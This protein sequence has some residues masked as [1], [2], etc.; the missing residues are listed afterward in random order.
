MKYFRPCEKITEVIH[1]FDTYRN[2]KNVVTRG[3]FNPYSFGTF[4]YNKDSG[5]FNFRTLFNRCEY[6]YT[7]SIEKGCDRAWMKT[8]SPAIVLNNINKSLLR[9]ANGED[10][11]NLPFTNTSYDDGEW[12]T[13]TDRSSP[14]TIYPQQNFDDYLY[15]IKREKKDYRYPHFGFID[16]DINKNQKDFAF[17]YKQNEFDNFVDAKEDFF[18]EMSLLD[19]VVMFGSS[20]NGVGMRVIYCYDYSIGVEEDDWILYKKSNING[21]IHS[22]ASNIFMRKLQE[23][24]NV[25]INSSYQDLSTD[26]ISQVT[27]LFG[28][29][30]NKV[31]DLQL[32]SYTPFEFDYVF[33][34]RKK[35]CDG[36]KEEIDEDLL[37][38]DDDLIKKFIDMTPSTFGKSDKAFY[39]AFKSYMKHNLFHY[40]IGKHNVVTSMLAN[41][42]NE[43]IYEFFWKHHKAYYQHHHGVGKGGLSKPLYSLK[44]YTNFCKKS[45]KTTIKCNFYPLSLYN[46]MYGEKYLGLTEDKKIHNIGL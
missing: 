11:V 40:N 30:I 41:I 22:T 23:K 44:S 7:K 43:E 5:G 35:L 36:F 1:S 9:K 27:F 25:R 42:D 6:F 13:F 33:D 14:T 45:Y 4:E 34:N 2:H 29:N 26:K 10:F 19:E 32:K 38:E 21:D 17:D 8:Y 20:S 39:K 3:V 12:V 15:Y 46:F 18:K 28:L 16:I 31:F 37:G 24:Y